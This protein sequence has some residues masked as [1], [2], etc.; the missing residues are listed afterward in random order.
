LRDVR[1]GEK[2]SDEEGDSV[3][4]DVASEEEDAGLANV[5]Q[6]DDEDA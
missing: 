4:A 1:R 6:K 2:K 5:K 3:L